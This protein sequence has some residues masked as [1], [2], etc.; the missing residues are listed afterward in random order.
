MHLYLVRHAESCQNADLTGNWHPDDAPLTEYG[1][2]QAEL[3]A[4]REDLQHVDT[5]C[6]STLLRAA[7]TAF[8]LAERLDKPITLADD[9]IER[10]TSIFGTERDAMLKEVPRAVWREW[11]PRIV[12]DHEPPEMLRE[13]A[14]RLIDWIAERSG[15]NESVMLVTHCAFFGYPLRCALHLPEDEPFAWKVENAAVTHIELRHGSIPLLHC[16]NERSH[17]YAEGMW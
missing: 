2:R 7:Q 10:D 13:R 9:A 3:L 5:I 11:T 15:E 1:K 14:K 12:C 17:L 8:P 16:A 4:L 6:A